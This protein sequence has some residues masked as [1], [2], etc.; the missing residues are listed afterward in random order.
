MKVNNPN[1][2]IK[3]V[4]DKIKN[5]QHPHPTLCKVLGDYMDGSSDVIGYSE[6]IDWYPILY[7]YSKIELIKLFNEL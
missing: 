6:N 2:T 1:V 4:E 3:N 7:R 5:I